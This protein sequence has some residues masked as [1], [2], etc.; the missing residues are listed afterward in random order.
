M[1]PN[2]SRFQESARFAEIEPM[3]SLAQVRE[4]LGCGI[5][6]MHELINLGLRHQGLHPTLGGLWPTFKLSHKCRRV[7][8]G[9]IVRHEEHMLRLEVDGMW[10]AAQRC[11]ASSMP[12]GSAKKAWVKT[13][14]QPA[15]QNPP[16]PAP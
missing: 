7:P 9:A 12:F 11:K 10:A 4:R 8:L 13:K 5:T 3:L 15:V 6:R 14:R 2:L 1:K 16:Q